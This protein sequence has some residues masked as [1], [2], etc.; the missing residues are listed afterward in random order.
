[1]IQQQI[2]KINFVVGLLPFD[3]FYLFETFTQV[4]HQT[5]QCS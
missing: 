5:P 4:T 1:M 3:N 2:Q